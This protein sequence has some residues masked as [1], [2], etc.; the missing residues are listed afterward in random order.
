MS[1]GIAKDNLFLLSVAQM[2][3][4]KPFI[5]L[6]HEIV[7]VD[8]R[9]V[10]SGIISVIRNDPHLRE[11]PSGYGP[12]KTIYNRLARWAASVSSTGSSANWHARLASRP[13]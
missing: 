3:R 1:G 6:S 2:R 7:M 4:I 12:H 13:G 10:I 5:L 9:R 11:A 8:D